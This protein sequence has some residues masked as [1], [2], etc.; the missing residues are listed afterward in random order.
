MSELAGMTTLRA[1]N[2]VPRGRHVVSIGTFD[3]VHLGHQH[4]LRSARQRA[5]ELGVPLLAVTF[6]PPPAQVI[7]PQSFPG[8][9]ATAERKLELLAGCGV[10]STLVLDFTTELM[11]MSPETFLAQ[12]NEAAHPVELWVG[13]EF[14]LGHNRVGNVER[15]TEIGAELGFQVHAVA[16]VEL[17]GEVVSSSRIRKQVMAGDAKAAHE[18]LGHP[19]QISGVVIEGAKVGRTI[20]YPTANVAPPPDLVALADG[21]YVSLA[22]LP[23]EP[24]HRPA[25]TYIGTRPA[26]NT[27]TRL[28]ETH[29]LDFSGDLYGLSLATDILQ[30]IRP[31]ATFAGVEALVR[32]LRDDER[33]T[34]SILSHIQPP[35]IEEVR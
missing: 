20:G 5:S 34:R 31:D 2:E 4:L 15:L 28:I 16:R 3:G 6:E 9:L 35:A 8:R 10:A 17:A 26:L 24:I 29:L 25:M 30:R 23:G 11:R 27:G 19:F 7:R 12:L 1:L 18:L 22:E 14:A 21:I 33:A 32:Q 13:E